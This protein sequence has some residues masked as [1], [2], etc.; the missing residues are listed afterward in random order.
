MKSYLDSLNLINEIK[1]HI[2]QLGSSALRAEFHRVNAMTMMGLQEIFSEQWIKEETLRSIIIEFEAC[3][4]HAVKIW[5]LELIWEAYYYL[6]LINYSL[7][8]MFEQL[9]QGAESEEEAE[10][11]KGLKL[12]FD[13]SKDQHA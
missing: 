2:L 4:E 7:S 6:S 13:K 5:D 11:L 10:D 3:L 1:P 12:E 8:E 9:L